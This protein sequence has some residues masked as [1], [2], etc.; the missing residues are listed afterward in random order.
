[1]IANSVTLSFSLLQIK[2]VAIRE[3]AFGLIQNRSSVS[4]REVNLPACRNVQCNPTC[5]SRSS[6]TLQKYSTLYD[7]ADE[8][9]QS[10]KEQGGHKPGKH[11]KPGKLREFEKLLKS[12]GKLR[13]NS[14]KSIIFAEKPGKGKCKICHIIVNENVFQGTFLSRVSQGKV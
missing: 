5:S 2:S 7:W 8:T 14:G 11:G 9:I 1:M 13:E 10:S 3:K 4:V 6:T 12:Q